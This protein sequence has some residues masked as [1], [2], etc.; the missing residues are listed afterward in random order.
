[1]KDE[2]FEKQDALIRKS[3]ESFR[4][5]EVPR[6]ILKG[7]REGVEKK[8]QL[9]GIKPAP[10]A[11]FPSFAAAAAVILALALAGGVIFYGQTRAVKPPAEAP[12]VQSSVQAEPA[13]AEP[14]SQAEKITQE[15]V[16]DL[17]VEMEADPDVLSDVEVLEALGVW[18][19]EDDRSVGFDVTGRFR[20]VELLFDSETLP[21][22]AAV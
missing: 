6:E 12:A 20:E 8:I 7:F 2:D 11:G 4:T 22:P 18:T 17:N 14:L 13:A 16:P 10:A 21:H 19:E 1:M 15:K 5:G 9:G 3:L